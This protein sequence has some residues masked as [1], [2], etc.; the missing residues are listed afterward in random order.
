MVRMSIVWPYLNECSDPV[1]ATLFIGFR[2]DF[3]IDIFR[4]TS[5]L[6]FLDEKKKK[7]QIGFQKL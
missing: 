4:Q 7:N 2:I 5:F 6:N 1:S 3:E